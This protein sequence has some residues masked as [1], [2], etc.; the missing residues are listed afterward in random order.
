MKFL[1][2]SLRNHLKEAE[3]GLRLSFPYKLVEKLHGRLCEEKLKR[4][5]KEW[6]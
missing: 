3:V 4:R 1:G 6:V 5:N 2:K